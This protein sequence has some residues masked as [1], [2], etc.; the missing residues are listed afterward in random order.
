MKLLQIRN[1]FEVT[2]DLR[3]A[4]EWPQLNYGMFRRDGIFKILSRNLIPVIVAQYCYVRFSN[5]DREHFRL[6]INSRLGAIS[7]HKAFSIGAISKKNKFKMF[8]VSLN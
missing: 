1:L 5:N 6:Q 4:Q 8:F 7:F 2:A 3:E